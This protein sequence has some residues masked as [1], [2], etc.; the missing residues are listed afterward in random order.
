MV[1]PVPRLALWLPDAREAPKTGRVAPALSMSSRRMIRVL[2]MIH[3]FPLVAK[4]LKQ[5]RSREG[6]HYSG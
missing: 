3:L 4:G 6:L 1:A 5:A 2:D